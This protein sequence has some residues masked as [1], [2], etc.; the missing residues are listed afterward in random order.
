M[1]NTYRQWRTERAPGSSLAPG[2][3]ACGRVAPSN[4]SAPLSAAAAA[5]A[6]ASCG[7]E[8]L[9]AEALAG[10]RVE[11]KVAQGP[12]PAGCLSGGCLQR[13]LVPRAN[14][15]LAHATHNVKLLPASAYPQPCS[16]A[17]L[18]TYEH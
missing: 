16:W 9:A 3:V 12:R 10:S 7:Q 8:Q 17:L 11:R 6:A 14:L 13:Q 1:A 18:S 15:L 4:P 2:V 5:A